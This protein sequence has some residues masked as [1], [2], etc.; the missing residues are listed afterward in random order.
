MLTKVAKIRAFMH[1]Q[2]P[3]GKPA[4]NGINFPN[5]DSNMFLKGYSFEA[6]T[7]PKN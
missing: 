7:A 2:A 6:K 5:M 1:G 3:E 4:I